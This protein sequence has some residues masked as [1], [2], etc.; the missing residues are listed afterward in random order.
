MLELGPGA[1]SAPSLA[2][3]FACM[4][5]DGVHAWPAQA[6]ACLAPLQPHNLQPVH[7]GAQTL[8]GYERFGFTRVGAATVYR[9]WAPAATGA[10]LI[11]D[12]NG[13]AG[14]ALQRDA[15][16]VWSVTLPDGAAAPPAGGWVG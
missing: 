16:G 5:S 9:E 3:A 10:Q 2:P 15:E 4:R 13:W 1:S 6:K 12:F 14:T 7:G 11:G 8:Q